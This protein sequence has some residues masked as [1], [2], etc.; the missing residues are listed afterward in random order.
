ML[1]NQMFYST[2]HWDFFEYF[3]QHYT[4][5]YIIHFFLAAAQSIEGYIEEAN[6]LRQVLGQVLNAMREL[7]AQLREL[8]VQPRIARNLPNEIVYDVF[9]VSRPDVANVG[10]L[11]DITH[12]GPLADIT[13]VGPLA[14]VA[15]VAP[16]A[17]VAN[18]GPLRH[19]RRWRLHRL[20][21]LLRRNRQPRRRRTPFNLIHAAALLNLIHG[22]APLNG[23]HGGAHVNGVNGGAPVVLVDYPDS[24]ESDP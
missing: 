2:K 19:W 15:H 5:S 1:F 16:L 9:G 11:A 21:R 8:G 20:R 12:V 18:G 4:C 10:P 6:Q 22:A 24:E 23:I 3:H 7:V 17:E 13:H 14:D